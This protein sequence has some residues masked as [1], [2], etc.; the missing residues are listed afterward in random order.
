MPRVFVTE[1]RLRDII[2]HLVLLY[3]E[4]GS[5]NAV[6]EILKP[7]TTKPIH[8]NRLHALLSANNHR[9]INS[10]TLEVIEEVLKH[11]LKRSATD[12]V[13]IEAIDKLEDDWKNGKATDTP[14]AVRCYARLEPP[15]EVLPKLERYYCVRERGHWFV[16]ERTTNPMTGAVDQDSQVALVAC[17]YNEDHAE[18]LVA[19]LRAGISVVDDVL[20]IPLTKTGE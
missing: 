19:C 14:L 10:G 5:V 20:V 2:E 17:L 1:P 9:A 4:Y 15:D 3:L 6:C 8:A 18:L 13:I 7:W 16:R 12:D 11:V